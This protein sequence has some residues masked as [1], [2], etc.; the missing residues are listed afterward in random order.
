MAKRV[1]KGGVVTVVL[2]AAALASAVLPQARR[3]AVVHLI[4][5]FLRRRFRSVCYGP[6]TIGLSA[7]G[8]EPSDLVPWPPVRPG[9]EVP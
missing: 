9:K 5:A 3:R 8:S 6:S 2:A 7:S 1:W 4:L